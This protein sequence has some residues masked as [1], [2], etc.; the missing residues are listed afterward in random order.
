MGPQ[1]NMYL[2]APGLLA[3]DEFLSLLSILWSRICNFTGAMFFKF[4]NSFIRL[5]WSSQKSFTWRSLETGR[6]KL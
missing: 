5:D 1:N 4:V 2:S 6:S 3:L